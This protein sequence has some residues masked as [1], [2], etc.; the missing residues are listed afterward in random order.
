MEYVIGI[1]DDSPEQVELLLRFLGSYPGKDSF[2][3]V[4]STKPEAFFAEISEKRPDIVLLDIDMGETNGIQL[5]EKIKALY[6]QAVII[7]IT[8]HEEYAL[9]AFAV[10][11][12]HYLLKPLAKEQFY[13]VMEEALAT[14][15]RISWAEE[16]PRT[17]SIQIKGE[18][19]SIP[20]SDIACFEKIG[21]RIKIHAP[22]RDVYYY[23][24]MQELPGLL[25]SS[26]F[27]QCH[28]GYIVNM[29]KIRSFREKTLYLENGLALPVSRPY[30]ETVRE[31]LAKRLF[32]GRVAR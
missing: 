27:L 9:K 14:I 11:A 3:A 22:G 18:F 8:A 20:Y 17:F 5:G 24:N 19:I 26:S 4:C 6:P 7:Y 23:G 29:E 10:R 15:R 1:C 30:M 2:E 31:A 21:R 28:Q 12:F 16:P 25:E 32:A 13:A